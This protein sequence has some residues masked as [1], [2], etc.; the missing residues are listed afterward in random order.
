MIKKTV[1]HARLA[2]KGEGW[3]HKWRKWGPYVSERA[4]GTVRED[5][6]NNGDAWT[7]FPFDR[8]ASKAYRWGDD[9]IAGWCDRYQLLIVAPTFWN[10]KDPILKERLFGLS[11]PE[12][13]HGEDVKEYYYHLDGT[14]T[15]SY[16]KFLYK[17]P[18]EE[19]P[20]NKIREENRKLGV[21]D[22]E[23]ELVDTGIFECNR[24]FDIVVEYAK[25]E[26]DDLCMRIT[27]TNRG[28]KPA[29]LHILPT[30]WFRN[31]WSWGATPEPAPQ[32]T[33]GKAENGCLCLEAD[34]AKL[35]PLQN[36]PFD[37]AIGK[38]F[39]YGPEKGAA[40]FTNNET[41]FPENR[42]GHYKDAFH[43]YLIQGEREAINPTE[44]GTKACLHYFLPDIAPQ[45]SVSL[46]FRF[47]HKPV[48]QPLKEVEKI[49][50][51]RKKE[52]D[53]FYQAILSKQASEE[54]RL[55]QRQAIAGILWSKQ[56]YLIDVDLWLKGD[57]PT[58][59]PP[60]NRVNIRNEH[61]RHLNSMRI[62]AMPDKWE[63]P[64]FCAWDQAFHCLTLALADI[65]NA[66]E[67]LWL[68]LFDQY[69]HPS[70]AIPAC[71]WEFSDLNPPVQSW[72]AL[73]LFYMEK[74][75]FGTED[76]EFLERCFHK[77]LMNFAW[78]VNKVDNSGSNVFEGG[79]LGLDNITILDRS[80]KLSEGITLQQSDGT[81]WMAMFCQ[82][83]MHI[84]LV[85]AAKNKVY[86]T[87]ATKFFQHYIY[88]AHAMKKRDNQDY[89]LWSEKDQ[90]FYDVLTYPDGRY[91]KFRVRSLV[92]LIPLYAVEILDDN[93]IKKFPEFYTNFKWF[94]KNRKDIVA[95]CIMKQDNLYVLSMM[96][97]EQLT[98]VLEYVWNPDEFRSPFG[99]RS[100]SK[101]HKDNPFTY[102]QNT[103]HYET[104]ESRF[105][106]KGG[107]SN[108]RGPVWFPTT[109]LMIDALKKYNRVFGKEMKIGK[110]G[111]SLETMIA[112]FS[113]AQISIFLKNKEGFR[114]FLGEKFPYKLDPHWRDLL[115]FNEYFNP[116]SGKG[117]G[118]SHQTGWTALVA[119]IINDKYTGI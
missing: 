110:E 29:P 44:I 37:Y 23:Y 89:E 38:H 10:G 25:K 103:I 107:N 52:A 113:E 95:N 86:E 85:L 30:V 71:E 68:L 14:P 105:K 106:F 50:D 9:A 62:L 13:N 102:G 26:E 35:K 41:R 45:A 48:S 78:W 24:Y 96:K 59:P 57:N 94:L 80:Q 22:P 51:E 82:N 87:L 72:A 46:L 28:S 4:W 91:D 69:Q 84:A 119:N 53:D 100:L 65:E 116:E 20:Y 16:M 58:Y 109:Y 18:Q 11:S 12:G 19:F 54:E 63:Y 98:K 101:F 60:S 36:L 21:N 108:W 49:I 1:E 70:G 114:P 55:I 42:E 2:D 118:A 43:R 73:Q 5:Y 97:K 81:G 104:D 64:Y 40:L 15:H 67:M 75:A 76:L 92:G 47:T 7:Y 31:Q 32:I 66:K 74:Q 115:L 112:Y 34:E 117:L 77:M 99:L 56:I 39:F 90:F 88:I 83:L 61:W 8:A 17:Y 93:E 6:S 3:V 79:F 33:I 27:A 111:V